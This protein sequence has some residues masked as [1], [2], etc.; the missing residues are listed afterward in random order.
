MEQSEMT[1]K[2]K[3]N[4]CLSW[5]HILCLTRF[6]ATYVLTM[7]RYQINFHERAEI[8]GHATVTYYKTKYIFDIDSNDFLHLLSLK[9]QCA[10]NTG[11]SGSGKN[12][13][14]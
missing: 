8:L 14:S 5:H 9:W 13:K 7:I 6:F 10:R 4:I 12:Q 3:Q 11:R 1:Q 2:Q